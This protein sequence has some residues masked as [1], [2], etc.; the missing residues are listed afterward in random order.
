MSVDSLDCLMKTKKSNEYVN[1]LAKLMGIAV[2][3][4]TCRQCVSVYARQH[5]FHLRFWTLL[6]SINYLV[7][8][9]ASLVYIV[10]K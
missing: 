10:V 4:L 8:T 5:L 6:D 3:R 2:K 1:I 7:W 9:I